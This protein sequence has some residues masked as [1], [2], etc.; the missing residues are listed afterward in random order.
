MSIFDSV[1][2]LS[3]LGDSLSGILGAAGNVLS[4]GSKSGQSNEDVEASRSLR[5]MNMLSNGVDR[6]N[7]NPRPGQY[8]VTKSQAPVSVD[9]AVSRE[10]WL[11]RLRSYT[12]YVPQPVKG[13]GK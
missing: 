1:G 5:L 6:L 7:P 8:E 9:P 4:S 3:S 13:A 10:Q 11:A 12:D 2:D